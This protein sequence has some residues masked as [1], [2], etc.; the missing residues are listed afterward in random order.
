[1]QQRCGAEQSQKIEGI[2]KKYIRWILGLEYNTPA[3]IVREEIKTEKMQLETEIR[4]QKYEERLRKKCKSKI[5]KECWNQ[6]KIEKKKKDR[7]GKGR[8]NCTTR[9]MEWIWTK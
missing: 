3:Y 8:G 2:Q 9:E 4:A 5:I 7:D 6:K 1:M